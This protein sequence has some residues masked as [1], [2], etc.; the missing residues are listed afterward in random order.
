MGVIW[1]HDPV[2]IIKFSNIILLQVQRS[3]QDDLEST[4]AYLTV[5]L[6]KKQTECARLSR[7]NRI[8]LKNIP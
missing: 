5:E 7:V 1:R 2:S 6:G 3:A 8:A 4:I